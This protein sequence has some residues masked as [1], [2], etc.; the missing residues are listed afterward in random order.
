MTRY[1]DIVGRGQKC[2]TYPPFKMSINA[3]HF[4]LMLNSGR[5]TLFR[6]EIFI[7]CCPPFKEGGP[8][9][10]NFK[11][12]VRDLKHKFGMGKPKGGIV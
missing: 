12:V 11:S 6:W 10:E 9:L 8:D 4:I 1:I 2:G 3:I 5:A 7:T